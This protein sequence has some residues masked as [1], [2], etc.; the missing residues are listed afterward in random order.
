MENIENSDSAD[1]GRNGYR[2]CYSAD[3]DLFR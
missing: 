2:I 3:C 1:G